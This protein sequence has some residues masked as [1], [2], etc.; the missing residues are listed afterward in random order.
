MVKFINIITFFIAINCSYGS[1]QF[2]NLDIQYPDAKIRQQ[3]IESELY[4]DR[5]LK[6]AI[7]KVIKTARDVFEK[8]EVDH[9]ICFGT[10][11]GA[12]RDGDIIEWDDDG[13]LAINKKHEDKLNSLKEEFR[14]LGY[15]LFSD[16]EP[17]EN[18]VGYKLYSTTHLQLANGKKLYP[19]I[20]LFLYQLEEEKYILSREK[21]RGI[22]PR[23]WFTKEQIENKKRYNLGDIEIW[24]PSD[25]QS[26]FT[27]NYGAEW[28]RKAL[29]YK[30]HYDES[31]KK[32]VWSLTP[33]QPYIA[34]KVESPKDNDAYWNSFYKHVS[35]ERKPSS[36]CEFVI[37]KGYTKPGK[38]LVDIGCGNGRDTFN[39]VNR[40]INAVGIDSSQAA[41][42]S[43]ISFAKPFG[44]LNI[45][46]RAMS[47]N[48]FEK[49]LNFKDFDYI[50]ARF[51]L[52]SITEEDQSVFLKFLT[53]L[54]QHSS[55]LLEFRTDK[56]PLFKKSQK[57]SKNEGISIGLESH[58]R[59]YINFDQFCNTLISLNF[60]LEFA[61]ERDGLSIRGDDNPFLARII[62]RKLSNL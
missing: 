34:P 52:H 25:P 12:V 55:V 54:K 47:V 3:F 59:R 20:D 49:L 4:T 29:H 40:G 10:F 17:G 48:Q 16:E 30:K 62:A 32:Y 35:L 22:F 19:F 57:I 38:A 21:G 15:N 56:D 6:S 31:P 41:I 9:W 13:D 5:T 61:E 11:L 7:A 33:Q 58:Y 2:T 14:K 23:S 37:D 8:H 45:A 60:K 27:R 44:E 1:Q 43:N 28:E 42:E 26:Y 24:G 46:F 36:F 39:F 18:I 50:Y 51:F 53:H